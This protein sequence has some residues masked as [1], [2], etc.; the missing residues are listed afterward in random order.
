VLKGPLNISNYDL[1][2]TTMCVKDR[3]L[4]IQKYQNHN[5]FCIFSYLA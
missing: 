5:F 3:G 1:L 2:V 4:H